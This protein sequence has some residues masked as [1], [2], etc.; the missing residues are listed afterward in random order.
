MNWT[1][2]YHSLRCVL[3]LKKNLNFIK[4]LKFATNGICYAVKNEKSFRTHTLL[5]IALL[6]FSVLIR[7]SLIWAAIFCLCVAVVM[8][9]ELVNSGLESLCDLIS[10]EPNHN[11]KVA[12]DCAAGAVLISSLISVVVF[13]LFLGSHF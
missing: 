10:K 12:K 4:R 6:F 13:L 11:I 8:G 9:L 7:P 5:A 3:E 1:G 2:S